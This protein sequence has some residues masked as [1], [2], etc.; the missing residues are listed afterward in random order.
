VADVRDAGD[1]ALLLEL[2]AVIDPRVNARVIAIAAAMRAEGIEGVRDIVSTFRSVAVYFDPLAA[3]I[4]TIRASLERAASNPGDV[5]DGRRV[6]VPVVYGGEFGPDLEGVADFA[7]L[8]TDQVIARHTA[9]DYRVYTLGFFPGFAYMGTVA[10]EIAAPR[11]ATP[12]VQVPGGSVGIAGPQT[13]V[14]PR[15]SPGG[16]QIIG[17]TALQMFDASKTPPALLA[18]GDT[19]RFVAAVRLEPHLPSEAPDPAVGAAFRRPEGRT[20]TILRPGLFTTV[21]DSGRW[22]HQGSGVPVSGAMDL[23]SHRLANIAV[24]NAPEAATLEATLLGPELRVDGETTVAV[25][26]ADLGVTIDGSALPLNAPVRCRSGAVLR[27]SGRRRGARAYIACDGGVAVRPVFGSRATHVVSAMGGVAG[28]ALRAGDSL[29]LG[30]PASPSP[31]QLDCPA[32]R[33]HGG[34]RLRVM[35]GPQ[36]QCFPDA[37]FDILERG[38]FTVSIQSDRMG[39]R[40]QGG[41]IPRLNEREMISDATFAGAIQVPASGQPILLMADRQTT[42]GY[43][44]IATVITADLPLAAQLAPG[45]WIEFEICSRADAVQALAQQESRLR[46]IG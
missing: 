4:T 2:D 24:G 31:G 39:Y 23:L 10:P 40:L 36:I 25:S 45:D 35:R 37:A 13:A 44:Q 26:G 12:R 16:W 9:G 32:P 43:P 11:R 6:E 19:V 3:D 41:H 28:R 8:T 15:D 34:A 22:G 33:S 42:G 46:A 29:P 20:V 27:F 14:Y 1:S 7:G 5:R 18:P 30:S 17:R 21:Q 38:R